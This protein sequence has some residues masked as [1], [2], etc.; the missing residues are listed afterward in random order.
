MSWVKSGGG[1]PFELVVFTL[2]DSD[3]NK[4]L[5]L[6]QDEIDELILLVLGV[7]S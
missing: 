4:V 1:D 7:E 5:E 2:Y 6:H 3:G